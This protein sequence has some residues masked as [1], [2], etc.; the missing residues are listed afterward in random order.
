MVY[1]RLSSS[2]LG[3]AFMVLSGTVQAQCDNL[4]VIVRNSVYSIHGLDAFCTEF[5]RMKA[6]LADMRSELSLAKREGRMLRAQLEGIFERVDDA[7]LA[8]ANPIQEGTGNR[9]RSQ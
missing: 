8:R 6:E 4:R 9:K 7:R 1:R 5:N 2:V 3:I